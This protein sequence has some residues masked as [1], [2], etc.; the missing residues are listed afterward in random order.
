[1]PLE[2]GEEKL[3]CPDDELHHQIKKNT[4]TN[5]ENDAVGG[6][7]VYRADGLFVT[8]YKASDKTH[9][10]LIGTVEHIDDIAY[11]KGYHTEQNVA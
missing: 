4:K 11:I 8:L 5:E 9:V 2:E 10:L 7:A 1:M 6:L 3:S